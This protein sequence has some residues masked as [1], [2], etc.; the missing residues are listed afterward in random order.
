MLGVLLAHRSNTESRPVA[1]T[2]AQPAPPAAQPARVAP[3]V[4]ANVVV[5]NAPATLP[6][7]N[8]STQIVYL[9]PVTGKIVPPPGQPDLSSM[10]MTQEQRN[11]ISTSSKGLVEEPTGTPA[12]G[13]KV[14]LQGRF[15]KVTMVA[16]DGNGHIV[17]PGTSNTVGNAAGN[18]PSNP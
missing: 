3:I 14:N 5:T 10:P 17:Q 13:F 4:S 2:D 15:H 7:Q 8:Q 16:L 6:P 18:G 1:S 11:A 9:D 12:G